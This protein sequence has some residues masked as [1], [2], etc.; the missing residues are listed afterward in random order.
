[1]THQVIV[2]LGLTLCLCYSMV[3][4]PKF[5]RKNENGHGMPCDEAGGRPAAA[6]I[7]VF[8]SQSSLKGFSGVKLP[9]WVQ[10]RLLV[11]MRGGCGKQGWELHKNITSLQVAH[12]HQVAK[13]PPASTVRVSVVQFA[14][15]RFILCMQVFIRLDDIFC[16]C[17]IWVYSFKYYCSSF[18]LLKV[19]LYLLKL[20]TIHNVS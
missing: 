12:H 3:Q 11:W 9:M 14:P 20:K 8:L 2:E 16:S 6:R 7:G 5:Q 13:S 10:P 18:L 1:M 4:S 19:I 17:V 15:C